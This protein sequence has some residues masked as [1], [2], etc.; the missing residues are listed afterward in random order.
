[1]KL[2]KINYKLQSVSSSTKPI[3]LVCSL[4]TKWEGKY[5]SQVCSVGVSLLPEE[6]D[7]KT[8]LPRK[9]DLA[10]RFLKAKEFI[11]LQLN[12]TSSSLDDE[13]IHKLYSTGYFKQEIEESIQKNIHDKVTPITEYMNKN[14]R[15]QEMQREEIYKE[16]KERIETSKFFLVDTDN[17]HINLDWF[18]NL[19]LES[20]AEK[21]L[22]TSSKLHQKNIV[23]NELPTSPAQS[24]LMHDIDVKKYG[25]IKFIEFVDLVKN[26][27]IKSGSL[28]DGS[29]YNVLINVF[30]EFDEE[31]TVN[32]INDQV[33]LNFFDYLQEERDLDIPGFNNYKKWINAVFAF[34][35]SQ[36]AVQFNSKI[37]NIYSDIFDRTY[38]KVTRPYLSEE[39]LAH[40]LSLKFNSNN[41]HLEHA[42]DLFYI[43]CYTSVTYVD[44]PQ[45]FKKVEVK[46]VAGE[47]IK[48]SH[49][50][51]KKTGVEADIVIFDEVLS[52]L[53]KYNFTIN[54]ISNAYFNRCIKDTMEYA[55]FTEDFTQERFNTKSKQSTFKTDPFYK[56]IGTHTGRRSYITNMKKRGISDESIMNQ[57]QHTSKKAFDLYIQDSRT[58]NFENFVR[59]LKN[60]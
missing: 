14:F 46:S 35:T 53:E 2:F 17:K 56:F 4:N 29:A 13:G 44:L 32:E 15:W 8:N 36:L 58:T 24:C 18:F 57:S 59:E 45:L 10:S 9:A 16:V 3:Q 37:L 7:L 20:N 60:K 27:K 47:Q 23:D 6:W 11:E 42:R 33:F 5:L 41:K 48:Y 43:Q 28:S 40:V 30:N 12:Q 26:R 50:R 54:K 19:S 1:M 21:F 34:A 51:R 49:I 25:G 38:E 22:Q 55:G 31:I 39:M 52:L